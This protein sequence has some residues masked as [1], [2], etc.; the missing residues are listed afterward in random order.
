[1]KMFIFVMEAKI[2][3]SYLHRKK[4]ASKGGMWQCMCLHL[5]LAG[6]KKGYFNFSLQT[7]S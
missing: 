7:H 3:I 4:T 1:M 2:L 5:L 6:K